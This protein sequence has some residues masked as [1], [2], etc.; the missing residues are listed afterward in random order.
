MKNISATASPSMNPQTSA[1]TESQIP[2]LMQD[3]NEEEWWLDWGTG[4]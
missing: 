1:N 4:L 2:F 3:N